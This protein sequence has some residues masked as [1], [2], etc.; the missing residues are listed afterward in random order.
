VV[1]AAENYDFNALGALSLHAGV[2]VDH[3]RPRLD[4]AGLAD[5][6]VPASLG[7]QAVALDAGGR[8]TS[9][10]GTTLTWN[11]RGQ[12]REA[13]PPIPAAPEQYGI[14]AEMRR[15]A[16]ISGAG[17][18]L[19]V[20]EGSDRIAVLDGGGVAKELYLFAGV[21]HPLRVR[22]VATST[23]AY[24]E[25]DI[26]GNVR[27][28]RAPGGAS[29]GGYRYSAFGQTL[30][31]TTTVT[32]P[33]RWKG[34]WRFDLGGSVELYDA[35][36]RMWSPRLGTFLSIDE[37]WAHD[38][39]STL[40]GWPG[41]NPI[42]QRDPSGRCGVACVAAA[43]AI[44]IAYGS[45]FASDDAA[46]QRAA[47][48]EA[49]DSPTIALALSLGVV[50]PVSAVGE[51]GGAGQLASLAPPAAG[52]AGGSQ[53]CS[54]K[55]AS[56]AD[57]VKASGNSI[58]GAIGQINQA[59]LSQSDAVKAIKDV[60]LQSGRSLGPTETLPGGAQVVLGIGQGVG[61]PLVHVSAEGIATFGEATVTYGPGTA[62]TITDVIL[63]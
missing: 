9:L 25:L 19:Y 16:R 40:W 3:Q 48:P 53:S 45:V 5:A 56:V 34:M 43:V 27:A 4:G 47:H 61:V 63:K 20:H 54:S 17:T 44:A 55:A 26:A 50:A 28:L 13:A 35:R 39:K 31:D 59:G 49:E 7:G 11:T 30:E 51:L 41:Q 36:A 21:D 62:V 60:T 15:F 57:V 58:R 23:V 46:T 42:A 2:A 37:F 8:V 14:D 22:L 12:L 18:E 1:G 32:Q 52:L 24:Y 38:P 6:A 10:R 29:L 33:L